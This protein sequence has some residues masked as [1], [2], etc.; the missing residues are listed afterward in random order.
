MLR[1]VLLLLALL[2]AC[3]LEVALIARV[4]PQWVP[5]FAA[6]VVVYATVAV[7][8]ERVLAWLAPVALGRALLAPGSF[9]AWLFLLLGAWLVLRPFRR[10]FFPERVA[11][12]LG[13]ALGVS[14]LLALG[15]SFLL[16][17]GAG[18]PFGRGIVAFS[19]TALLSPG[20]TLL[21]AALAPRRTLERVS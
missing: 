8:E 4:G 3:G 19:T 17:D 2:H 9:T 15:S 16:M 1:P 12:Q 6:W 21:L 5:D 18:D 14:W 13:A 11:F 10:R 20:I 7:P